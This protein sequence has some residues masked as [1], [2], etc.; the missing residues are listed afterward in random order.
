[1]SN[2]HKFLDYIGIQTY[3]LRPSIKPDYKSSSET[4]WVELEKEVSNCKDCELH[5]TRT[6]TVFGCGNEQSDWLFIGEAPGKDEDLKGEPFVG[7]AGRLLN[8]VIFSLNLK[9]EDVYIANILKCRPPNNRDPS[10][11]EIQSCTTYLQQQIKMIS[12][13]IIIAVGRV[14]AQHLLNTDL[15]MAKLRGT[16]HSYGS[17]SIPLITIYHPAYLLRS[18]SQKH[19]VWSDLQVVMTLMQ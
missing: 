17:K 18:P 4:N 19:K 15:T 6:Q 1:M 12:P 5:K 14:A 13:K 8:E 16:V 7:R 2:L 11:D 3:V 9:R 10:Q